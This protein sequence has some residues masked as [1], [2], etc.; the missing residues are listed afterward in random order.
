MREIGMVSLGVEDMLSMQSWHFWEAPYIFLRQTLWV[1][2]FS[3]V[4]FF[5]IFYLPL[6]AT[7]LIVSTFAEVRYIP[8]VGFSFFV[9]LMLL[10]SFVSLTLFFFNDFIFHFFISWRGIMV[11]CLK[12]F[13]SADWR[14]IP[15]YHCLT[16]FARRT[17]IGS[18]LLIS[19][20]LIGL[21]VWCYIALMYSALEP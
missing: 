13:Y 1:A 20:T 14:I 16:P 9:V 17:T 12:E 11:S 6:S 19:C 5:Q 10:S 18:F 3:V 4:N 15:L 8:W 2:I 7:I 21:E